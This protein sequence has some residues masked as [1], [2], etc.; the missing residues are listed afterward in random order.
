MVK[1]N[2]FVIKFERVTMNNF[3]KLIITFAKYICIHTSKKFTA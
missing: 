1:N 2:Y 3:T